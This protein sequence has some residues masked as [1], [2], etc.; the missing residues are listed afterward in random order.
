MPSP[1]GTQT[2]VSLISGSNG[3]VSE[4]CQSKLGTIIILT[5]RILPYDSADT[6]SLP[7]EDFFEHNPNNFQLTQPGSITV[8]P[9]SVPMNSLFQF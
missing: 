4:C 7:M 1:K 5:V 6:G 9:T 3:P 8:T 2:H